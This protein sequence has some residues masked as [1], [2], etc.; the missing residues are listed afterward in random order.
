LGAPF[1]EQFPDIFIGFYV[2]MPMIVLQRLFA[3]KYDSV[4][5]TSTGFLSR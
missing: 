5:V 4:I 2:F 3:N 1:I